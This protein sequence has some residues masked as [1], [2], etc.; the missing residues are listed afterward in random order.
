MSPVST[1]N[2]P[3]IGY[4]SKIGNGLGFDPIAARN[5]DRP[6]FRLDDYNEANEPHNK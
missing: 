6:K 2:D 4:T 3:T 5:P 1:T